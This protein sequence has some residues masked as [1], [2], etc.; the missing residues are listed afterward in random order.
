MHAHSKAKFSIKLSRLFSLDI[1]FDGRSYIE[2]EYGEWQA[3]IFGGGISN[4]LYLTNNL[5][6]NILF[7]L[8]MGDAY[9]YGN[10]KIQDCSGREFQIGTIIRF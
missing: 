4:N 1:L 3:D 6:I 10:D 8:F 5:E 9:F 2:N 7:K